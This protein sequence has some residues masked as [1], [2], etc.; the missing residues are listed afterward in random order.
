MTEKKSVLICLHGYTQN[1]P[2][3]EKPWKEVISDRINT[4]NKF[5]KFMKEVGAEVYL[6][7]SGGTIVNGKVEADAVYE[8]AKKV[9]PEMFEIVDDVLLERESKN[10][11]ENVDQILKWALKKNA[12]IIAISSKDHVPRLVKDWAYEKTKGHQL[13]AIAPGE[14]SYS[15]K[16]DNNP[17]IVIEPP[18]FGYDLA[19]KLFDIPPQKRDEA[20]EKINEI[21]SNLEK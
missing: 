21:L 18:F 4:A 3:G 2:E 6:V 13:V 7:I 20:V 1:P 5:S 15:K 16:G 12:M 10:T 14:E 9:A 17:P 8:L 11:Q 19:K